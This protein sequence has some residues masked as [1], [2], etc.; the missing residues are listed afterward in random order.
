MGGRPA[1]ARDHPPATRARTAAAGAQPELDD[2][3]TSTWW[4][5]D[6]ELTHDEVVA[7]GLNPFDV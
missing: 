7:R 3:E 6:R 1:R 5:G 2:T 4:I